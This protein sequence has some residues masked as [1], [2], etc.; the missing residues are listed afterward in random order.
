MGNVASRRGIAGVWE[1]VVLTPEEARALRE[2]RWNGFPYSPRTDVDQGLV[3]ADMGLGWRTEAEPDK[4]FTVS[5]VMSDS[6]IHVHAAPDT[7]GD[8]GFRVKELGTIGFEQLGMDKS[9]Q[10]SRFEPRFRQSR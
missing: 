1:E 4:S 8:E 10:F 9:A 3:Q 6:A 5:F 2:Q 7:I